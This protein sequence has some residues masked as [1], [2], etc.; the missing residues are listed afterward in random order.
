[1]T[2]DEWVNA[3]MI[4]SSESSVED[5]YNKW[6]KAD[7]DMSGSITW[8]EFK[9]IGGPPK[10]MGKKL[11]WYWDNFVNGKEMTFEEFAEAS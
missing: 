7:V 3:S 2:F 4:E 9:L 6:G 8:D 11:R 1:M 10:E 5:I